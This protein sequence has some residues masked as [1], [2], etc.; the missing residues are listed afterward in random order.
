ML[1]VDVQ[2]WSNE[3]IENAGEKNWENVKKKENKLYGLL[4]TV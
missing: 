3:K 1:E 2:T 4:N